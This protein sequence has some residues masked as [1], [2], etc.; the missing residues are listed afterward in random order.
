MLFKGLIV[1]LSLS[2]FELNDSLPIDIRLEFRAG[3]GFLVLRHDFRGFRLDLLL[4]FIRK[5][6]G[7]PLSHAGA[8]TSSTS[9]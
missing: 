1:C 7:A 8:A 5:N 6:E 9:T 2:G 4:S 3:S